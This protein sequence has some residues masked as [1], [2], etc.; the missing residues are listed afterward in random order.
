MT[1][2]RGPRSL[3]PKPPEIG[4]SLGPSLQQEG[5]IL[6]TQP[7]SLRGRP[8]QTAGVAAKSFICL[9]ILLLLTTQLPAQNL[10]NGLASQWVADDYTSGGSW[11]DRIKGTVAAVDGLPA[12]AAVAGAFGTHK[13][14]IRTAGTTGTGGFAIPAPNPPTGLTNY[15]LAL[16]FSA[17]AAGP[18]SGAYYSSQIIFG[19]D[20]GGAGQPDWGISWGGDG[21]RAGQGVVAGIGRQGGDSPLES[22]NGPLALNTVHAAVLQVNGSTNTMTLFVDGVQAG[23][24]TGITIL[25]AT[26]RNGN[27]TIPLLSTANSTIA[28]AFP[29]LVAEVRVYTNATVSGT[30]L[31]SYLQN[32]YTKAPQLTLAATPA[33]ANRGATVTVQVTVPSAATQTGPLMVTLTSTN[34]AVVAGTNVVLVTGMTSTNV[35]VVVNGLGT[36]YLTAS[37]PGVLASTPLA[38]TGLAPGLP[39]PITWLRADAIAGVTNGGSLASWIDLTGNGF[40]ATQASVTQ[41]P[42]YVTNGMNGLPVVRFNSGNNTCLSLSRP[43]QDDFSIL[44]VFQSTQGLGSGTFY[45]QGAG[46]VNAEVAGVVD[47][48]GTCLFANGSV[49]A[50]TGNP[51]VAVDSATGYNDGHAHLLTFTRTRSTGLLTLYVDGLA[52][53]S[54]TG[55]TQSLTSPSLVVLGAQQTLINYLTGDISEVQIYNAALSDTNRLAVETTLFVK[56]N[57]P[58]PAP[59][60]LYL[61]LQNAGVVL[62]WLA[63]SGATGYHVK[64]ALVSGGP[65]TVIATNAATAFT[66]STASPTNV[67]YYVVSAVNATS[68]SVNSSEASTATLLN[69]HYILGPSSRKTPIAI[70]EIMWKPAPRADGKNLEFIEIFNSNPWYHDLSGYQIRCADMNYTFPAGTTIASNA[71]LVIAAAP[72]DVQA[73]YGITNLLGPYAGSLKKSETLQMF[74]EQGAL[75]LS[76]PYTDVFPW[77]VAAN[78]TGHSL[79]LADPTYGEGDP[80]SWALSDTVGGTP[81]GVEVFHPGPLR[82]ILINEILPHSENPAVPQ[83]IELYNHSTS[84]VDLSACVLTDDPS[85]NKFAIPPGTIIS[86]AGFI[87]FSQPQFGFTLSGAGG[88]LYLIQPDG[89]RILD[90]VQFGAQSDGVSYG[91][92]PDGANDFYAFT[93]RTPGTNNSAILIGDIVINELMYNPISG[94]DDDQYIELYNQGTNPVNLTGWQFS[95]GVTFTF[96]SITLAP[97]GYLVVARNLTNLLGKY[98][99]LNSA[100]TVGNYTGKLSH[101]GELVALSMPQTLNT[102]TTI[103][104]VEDQ[105]SYGTGGRWGQWAGGGGSSLELI[106]P[107][108]NHRLASNWADSIESQ[109]SVWTNLQFT[110]TLDNGA[111]YGSS[112]SYAQVGILDVGECLVDNVEVDDANGVNYVSNPTFESGLTNWSLQGDEVRSSLENSGYASSYSLHLR[113][114]DRYYNAVNSCQV[115]LNANSLVAGQTATLR[116]KARWLHGWPELVLRLNG[117]WLEATGAMPVPSNLG[118]PGLPNTQR[119]ANAGPAIYGVNHFPPVPAASQPVVVTVQVHDPNGLQSLNLNYRID[120]SSSYVSV[121]FKDDGTGGDAVP[122]DGVFSATIPGQAANTVV[123]FYVSATDGNSVT[124]RFPA[125]LADNTPTRECLVMF[126]DGNPGGSFGVYHLWISQSNIARWVNLGNLSNEG[127]DCTMVSGNRVIYN[128]QAHYQGSPVHQDYDTP[129]GSWCTYKWI[130]QDDDKFL[131]A[132]SFNKIHWPGNTANDPTIQREQLA[133]TFL[134]ALGVPWLNRRYVVVFVNGN[135]RGTLMEDAQ[136][137]DNDMVKEYFPNDSNGYLHKVNRWYEFAPFLSGEALP[138]SLASEAMIMP[139]ATTGGAKK[140]ARYRFTFEY[141]TTADSANNLTDVFTIIDAASAPGTANYVRNL[142]NLANMENWMRV[143]AANHAAGN[144]DSFGCSSGQNLYA[145]TGTLGTKSTL[146]MFDFNIGLGSEVNYPP[147]QDLFATVAGDNNIAGIYNEPTFRRMY[148]RALGE[149]LATGPLNLSLSVPLLNAKFAAFAANGVSV[150]DPNL[151]LIPWLAQASPLIAAQLNAANATNFVVNPSVAISNNLALL[152]GQAP[153]AV[154]AIWFNGASYPLTWTTVTNWM[155]TVP[156][157]NGTNHFDVVGVDRNGQ[158][159]VG[160]TGSANAVFSGTNSSP[161]GQVVI[162]EIMYGPLVAGAEF[163]ELYNNS[164]NT[165][166]DLS[167]WQ[168]AGLSYQ[169]PA[170]SVIGP[171]SFL[172]LAANNAAFAG[173]Y[174]ATNAVFDVFNGALMPNGT[175]ALI[176]SNGVTVAEVRYANQLPWPTNANG[177]GASLQLIDPRQDNWRVGNWAVRPFSATPGAANGVAATLVPFPPLWINELQADNRTGITNSAGQHTG[178]VEIFNPSTN[179]VSLGG[180]YLANNYTNLLQWAFPSNA[181]ISAGQFKVIF[182]DALTNLSTPNELHTSFVLGSGSGSVALTRL[183][184]TGQSQVLDYVDYAYLAPNDSFGSYPDGQS[185]SRQEL[186]QATPGAHNNGTVT[187][188]ASFID[189][190]VAGSI[191]TQG[192]DALPNPGVTS[193]NT[194]NP[195]TI[196]GITCSLANPFDF[197]SPVVAS[198]AGG[199]GLSALAGWYG[200]AALTSKFGATD[201]DQTTGGLLSFGVPSGSNRALGLLATSSTG[202]TAFGVRLINGTAMTLTRMNLQFTGEIWRQ[203]NLAKMLQFY[204]AVDPTGTNTFPATA[205]ASVPA[206]NVSFPTVAADAGGVAVDGTLSPN[207]TNLAVFNQVITNWAP[208]AALWLVWQ[209]SDPT[210][211]AQGLGIDNVSFSATPPPP[212]PLSVQLAGTNLL[213][214]WATIAGANYQLEYTHDLTATVWIPAGSPVLGTGQTMTLTNTMDASPQRFYRFSILNWF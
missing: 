139:Y 110:G 214:S 146:M 103:Y 50:G 101:K 152:T 198:G 203:S 201:G 210:G 207:Q 55:G 154:N 40:N 92:W 7:G 156:L 20:I 14:V 127:I 21:S 181:V 213:L 73:V 128:A 75:L 33:V 94:N 5:R 38:I 150:E 155:A 151:N 47:D 26:N 32:L 29:G 39:I 52:V 77:P 34:P 107:R 24:T 202:G 132:T 9:W 64:R 205:T 162:N 131:G 31:S 89:K 160:A 195:V 22:A 45:Y 58:P 142:E 74:D 44:C 159:I 168:I 149:L 95:S 15:T 136:T 194:A 144:W 81:G 71:F 98:T 174:G 16:A 180:L 163:V 116:F 170:G 200:S 11:V 124:S 108:A 171:R 157:Q 76:V 153:F 66:D 41:Q 206:L 208:G 79:V 197:A 70:T 158:P 10:T 191:Y 42:T 12:P 68:E 173:A 35:V 212:G 130:F 48:F 102:N 4:L 167:G 2:P 178:W 100:N 13:G 117:G 106:D 166:F 182:A 137:P 72:N 93:T 129:N 145:Y 179:A 143:F 175:L 193:V 43:I 65:Y 1:T 17:T 53:G 111:N 186:F 82:N 54:T 115:A 148:W 183:T 51:D 177:T 165:A 23:Q 25:A 209:M 88:T 204:Y 46:L 118:S 164:S 85:T 109:K 90:A 199:L 8:L 84:S 96:P 37:G 169:F 62:N 147:G 114:S 134:R 3:V 123:A 189:Y 28:N 59:A 135:R 99:N 185:F 172:V 86:P 141:R 67:Y 57:L 105:V 80:R 192:F 19:Y 49:A 190:A 188:A 97:N 78:G 211:K 6:G 113:C 18:A 69:F 187:P 140:P 133:N 30:A 104:V 87:S 63:S 36:A 138:V 91:R 125:L 61:Q 120:P 196:N 176:A 27:G 161:I 112:I 83:F 184:A 126:G 119:I 122:G 121:P 60:G 56:Y